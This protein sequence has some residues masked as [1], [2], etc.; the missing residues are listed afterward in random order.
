MVAGTYPVVDLPAGGGLVIQARVR[1]GA[2]APVRSS[3]TRTVT[4]T[5]VAN[6]AVT[7][8]VKATVARA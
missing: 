5:S 8:A 7:D 6:G 1:V 3:I 2:T 4:I